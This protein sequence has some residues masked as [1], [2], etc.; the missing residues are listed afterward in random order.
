[1]LAGAT[2]AV[3]VAG[4]ASASS[5]QSSD[6]APPGAAVELQEEVDAMRAAGLPADHPKVEMLQREVEALVAGTNAAPVPDPGAPAPGARGQAATPEQAVRLED[7]LDA[8][9]AGDEAESGAVECEPIPGALTAAE[10]ASA[11]TCLSVPEPDG[12]SRYLAVE[13]AGE[14][15]TVHFGHD[16]RVERLPDR[17]LPPGATAEDAV[18]LD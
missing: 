16:G 14:V 15:H 13:P 18:D 17:Q 7:Q 12:A 4:S 10:V 11:S 3:A 1:M 6:P 5:G 9:D 2:L 8:G